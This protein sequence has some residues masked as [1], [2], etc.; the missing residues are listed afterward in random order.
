MD[1]SQR[2]MFRLACRKW[3]VLLV[4]EIF[5]EKNANM[6]LYV[7]FTLIAEII[8]IYRLEYSV[9]NLGW[10]T[11]LCSGILYGVNFIAEIKHT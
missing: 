4:G 2:V 1:F 6:H 10:N 9:R 8:A 11:F 7:A 3:H 5:D